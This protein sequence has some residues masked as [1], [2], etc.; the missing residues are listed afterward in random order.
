MNTRLLEELDQS[1]KKGDYG[2]IDHMLVLKNSKKVYENSYQ[3]EYH[4]INQGQDPD[5]RYSTLR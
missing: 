4:K 2:Y 5:Y 3:N 1:F